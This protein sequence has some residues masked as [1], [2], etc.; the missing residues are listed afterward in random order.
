MNMRELRKLWKERAKKANAAWQKKYR[1][2]KIASKWAR[3]GAEAA[4]RA[5]LL[6]NNT[7]NGP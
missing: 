7:T 1:G 5:R 2:T 3:M 6:R 4:N